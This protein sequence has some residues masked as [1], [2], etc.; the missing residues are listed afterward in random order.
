MTAE[1]EE[2]IRCDCH[3][4]EVLAIRRGN[5]L[6]ITDRRHGERH[7]AVVVLEERLTERAILGKTE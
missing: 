6:V 3:G 7:T 5:R 2:K 1:K 4:V